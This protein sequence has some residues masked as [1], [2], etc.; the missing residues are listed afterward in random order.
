M[1]NA[2]ERVPGAP[3]YML[4]LCGCPYPC[5]ARRILNALQFWVL[6]NVLMSEKAIPDIHRAELAR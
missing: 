1:A 6:D 3:V 5:N 2:C 4:T